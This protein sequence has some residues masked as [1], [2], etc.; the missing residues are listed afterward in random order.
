MVF[1]PV[2]RLGL[3]VH[4]QYFFSAAFFPGADGEGIACKKYSASVLLPRA[5]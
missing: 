5:M 3:V 2:S 1:M 4:I